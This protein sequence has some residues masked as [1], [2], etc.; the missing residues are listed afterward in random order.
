MIFQ[1]VTDLRDNAAQFQVL[2]YGCPEWNSMLVNCFCYVQNRT[3]EFDLIQ[4]S[5]VG[6]N[7]LATIFLSSEFYK[8]TFTKNFH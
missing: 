3:A 4:Y 1:L 6:P 2:W 5:S 8:K 7:R